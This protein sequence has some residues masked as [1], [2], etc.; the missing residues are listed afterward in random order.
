M[1]RTDPV[2]NME[3]LRQVRAIIDLHPDEFDQQWFEAKDKCGTTR[4]V[5]GWVDHLTLGTVTHSEV[6]AKEQLGLTH[7]ES[8]A[9]FFD[10]ANAAPGADQRAAVEAVFQKIAARAGE[11]L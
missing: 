2:P 7:E 1:T 8:E 10:T 4:C 11:K 5:A 9:L 6:H 3:L